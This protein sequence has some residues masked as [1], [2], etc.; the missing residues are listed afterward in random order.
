MSNGAITFDIPPEVIDQIAER[1]IEKLGERQAP[2]DDGWLRGAA[3]IAEYAGCTPSR[4]YS[5]VSAGRIP[6]EK[7]GAAIVIKRSTLD[8][9]I[10]KGG[11]RCPSA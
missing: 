4:I 1:V 6:V 5:L 8:A 11:D 3:E 9:W 10:K 7:D 2:A